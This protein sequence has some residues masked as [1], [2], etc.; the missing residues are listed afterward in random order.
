M[1][2]DKSKFLKPDQT[3]IKVNLN[4]FGD[5]WVRKPKSVECDAL[6]DVPGEVAKVCR[7]A[8]ALCQDESGAPIFKPADTPALMDLPPDRLQP[9]TDALADA[10]GGD[11]VVEKLGTTDG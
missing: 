5:M 9:I 1:A 6:R 4:G 10:M 11:D 8:V 2:F 3:R 7:L